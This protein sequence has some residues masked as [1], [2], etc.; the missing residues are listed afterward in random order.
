MPDDTTNLQGLHLLLSAQFRWTAAS[1]TVLR[2]LIY[3]AFHGASES[4][5]NLRHL[6]R[7]SKFPGQWWA[8]NGCAAMP[9]TVRHGT[10]FGTI[11][12]RIVGA[13]FEKIT[14]RL[15]TQT[16]FAL[17]ATPAMSKIVEESVRLLQHAHAAGHAPRTDSGQLLGHSTL[18][19]LRWYVRWFTDM[20]I[21]TIQLR[22]RF[23]EMLAQ[24]LRLLQTWRTMWWYSERRCGSTDGG[25]A[26]RLLLLIQLHL[27]HLVNVLDACWK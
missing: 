25:A 8:T 11:I 20:A 12:R 18:G 14:G 17:R 22:G 15:A 3:S 19:P 16:I 7:G 6:G 24:A 27:I 21:V 5:D 1:W 4:L 23:A 26:A 13:F 2:V 10:A 9:W